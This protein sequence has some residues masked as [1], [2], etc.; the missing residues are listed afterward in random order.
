MGGVC[1][2]AVTDVERLACH[3]AVRTYAPQVSI[4]AVRK[5][6]KQRRRFDAAVRALGDGAP[7]YSLAPVVDGYMRCLLANTPSGARRIRCR[8]RPAAS[9]AIRAPN[10]S[11]SPEMRQASAAR[12]LAVSV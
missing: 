9:M 1:G 6:L 8:N 11:S 3:R 4:A 12:G 2:G 5:T 7:R 10:F